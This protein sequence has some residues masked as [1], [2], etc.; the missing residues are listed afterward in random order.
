[1]AALAAFARGVARGPRR[2]RGAHLALAERALQ[3]RLQLGGVGEQVPG[4]AR[5]HDVAIGLEVRAHREH[6]VRRVLHEAGVAL[7][8]VERGGCHRRDADV[9]ALEEA[10]IA[11]ERPP[12]RE[13]HALRRERLEHGPQLRLGHDR[14]LDLRVPLQDAGQGRNYRAQVV[15]MGARSAPADHHAIGAPCRRRRGR[16]PQLAREHRASRVERRAVGVEGRGGNLQAIGLAREQRAQAAFDQVGRARRRGRS[17]EQVVRDLVDRELPAQAAGGDDRQQVGIGDI[18]DHQHV[19]VEQQS[20]LE[21]C[22]RQDR[23]ADDRDVCQLTQRA[24]GLARPVDGGTFVH[25]LGRPDMGDQQ[26]GALA[27]ALRRRLRRRCRWAE[28]AHGR[29]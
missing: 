2:Y 17:G 5:P 10:V 1:M 14:Q 11:G 26:P 19:G 22:R 13:R 7:A 28:R 16:V 6:A 3:H 21:Q 25:R 4:F 9:D 15:A 27:G 23:S 12:G 8:P 24:A 18:A 29:F 20:R